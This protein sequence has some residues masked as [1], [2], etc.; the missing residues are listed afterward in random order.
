MRERD[1]MYEP[2]VEVN[3]FVSISPPNDIFGI[4]EWSEAHAEQ[5]VLELIACNDLQG[6]TV[7]EVSSHMEATFGPLDDSQVSHIKQVATLEVGRLA[8]A[9][10]VACPKETK[11][12]RKLAKKISEA[13]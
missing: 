12:R 2:C 3:D 5:C 9:T 7:R 11:K 13:C 4:R 6:I 1:T 10:E 8:V